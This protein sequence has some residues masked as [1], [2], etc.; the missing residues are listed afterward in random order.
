MRAWREQGWRCVEGE[1]AM[2]RPGHR[3]SSIAMLGRRR[4]GGARRGSCGGGGAHGGGRGGG[5]RRKRADPHDPN[6]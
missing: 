3:G 5:T 6:A 1:A 2:N 4:G